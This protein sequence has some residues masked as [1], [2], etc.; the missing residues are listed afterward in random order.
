[1]L[2][3]SVLGEKTKITSY[4]LKMETSVVLKSFTMYF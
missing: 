2:F 4:D 3:N 1:M